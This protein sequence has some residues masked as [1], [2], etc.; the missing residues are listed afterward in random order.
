MAYA[1]DQQFPS[2]AIG[3]QFTKHTGKEC[4]QEKMKKKILTPCFSMENGFTLLCSASAMNVHGEADTFYFV[5]P[6]AKA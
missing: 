1:P 3:V 2:V 6:Y 4:E 5:S